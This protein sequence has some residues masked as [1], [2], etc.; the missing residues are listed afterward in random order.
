[1]KDSSA[2][3]KQVLFHVLKTCIKLLHPFMPFITEEIWEKI[4]T[5]EGMIINAPWPE[6]DENFMFEKEAKDAEIFKE[7]VYRIRNIRGEMNIPPDKKA[8][9]VFKTTK[10][11]IESIIT[12]EDVNIKALAR[13][14]D[15]T[16]SADYKAANTDASAVMTDL[17]IFMPLADLID[18]DK[19]KARL[20]KEIGRIEGELARVEGKLSNEKFIGKAPQEIIDKEKGK[21]DEYMEMLGKL[22]QSLDKLK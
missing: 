17:E 2:T 21:K 16:I 9:V 4:T 6:V 13:V 14:E 5:G 10:A 19:E 22:R 3:A 12:R 7:I 11:D 8:S 15:I 1:M 20:E 18:I